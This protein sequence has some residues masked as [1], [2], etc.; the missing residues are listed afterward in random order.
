MA[1][2]DVPEATMK[3]LLGHMSQKMIERHSHIRQ[4]AKRKAV[5]GLRLAKAIIEIPE[6]PPKSRPSRDWL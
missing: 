4:V 1:E 2:N 3:A 6:D 5:D